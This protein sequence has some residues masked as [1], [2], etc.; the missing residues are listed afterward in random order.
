MFGLR[1]FL[2]TIECYGKMRLFRGGLSINQFVSE[3]GITSMPT[4][5]DKECLRFV[6]KTSKKIVEDGILS[7]E[8]S[9]FS[10]GIRLSIAP[11]AIGQYIITS[12]L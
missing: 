2:Q 1:L 5:A 11:P 10:Y 6:G 8:A 7:I 9:N 4:F 12:S 3:S